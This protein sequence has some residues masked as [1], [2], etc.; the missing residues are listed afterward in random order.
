VCSNAYMPAVDFVA[1]G[2]DARAG[3]T[4]LYLDSAAFSVPRATALITPDKSAYDKASQG[5]GAVPDE[6]RANRSAPG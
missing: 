3:S 4:N 1:D 5:L 2:P 6:L